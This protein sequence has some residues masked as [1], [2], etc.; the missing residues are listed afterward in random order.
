MEMQNLRAV[1]WSFKQCGDNLDGMAAPCMDPTFIGI[2][3]DDAIRREVEILRDAGF[4][5]LMIEGLR[6]LM[7]YEHLGISAQVRGAIAHAVGIAHDAGLRVFYHSTSTFVNPT[8]DGLSPSELA[9]LSIDGATGRYAHIDSWNGWYLWCLNNPDFQARYFHLARLMV[10]E[11]RVDGMMTDEVY[12]RSGWLDCA[13]PHCLAKFGAPLP[14]PDYERPEWRSW[15]RFRL[16]S[17]GDFYVGLR[18]AIGGIPLMGCKNDEPNPTH[19]QLYGENNDE[20]MRGTSILFTEICD[21]KLKDNWQRAVSNCA[22][23]QGLANRWQA[24]VAILGISDTSG[25]EFTYGLRLAHAGRPWVGGSALMRRSLSPKDNLSDVPGDVLEWKRLFQW[26]DR[27]WPLLRQ[28]TRPAARVALLLSA[29]TRDQY[30][31]TNTDFV[32]EYLGWNQALTGAHIPF[33]VITEAELNAAALAPFLAL[34]VPHAV[35]L[36]DLDLDLDSFAGKIIATGDS[37]VRDA[38]GGRRRQP[39]FAHRR[40]LHEYDLAEL[41]A[42][43]AVLRVLAAPPEMLIRPLWIEDGFLVHI[44]NAGNDCPGPVRMS[45]EK[46]SKVTLISPAFSGEI[47]LEVTSGEWTVPAE[48]LGVYAVVIV[49]TDPL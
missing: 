37:G 34:I 22:A 46:A 48:R 45:A 15:L 25:I 19:S 29:S 43:P 10:A 12:F 47:D 6:R 14:A 36:P 3:D 9:M 21:R 33:A 5:T 32:E 26:E 38:Q 20:R 16:Q 1:N 40:S 27:W 23:Y 28:A 31:Y 11:T 17:V 41:R 4:N 30:P 2:Q 49:R 39:L 42:L 44:V 35:C 24:P 13:C 18:R 7:L 8:L